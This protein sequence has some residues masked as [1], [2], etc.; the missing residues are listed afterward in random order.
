MVLV[1]DLYFRFHDTMTNQSSASDYTVIIVV[2]AFLPYD[3]MHWWF[4]IYLNLI[5]WQIFFRF[6]IEI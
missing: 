1:G 5:W 6:S 3:A 2:F 4:Y